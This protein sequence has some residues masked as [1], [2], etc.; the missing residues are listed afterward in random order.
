[1]SQ[2][3]VHPPTTVIAENLHPNISH[4][5]LEHFT[6]VKIDRYIPSNK[7][8]CRVSAWIEVGNHTD[9]QIIADTL[10]KTTISGK[11]IYCSITSSTELQRQTYGASYGKQ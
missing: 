4:R 2:I 3:E 7:T 8:L 11:T 6:H 1:M 9:A 5:E 10:N